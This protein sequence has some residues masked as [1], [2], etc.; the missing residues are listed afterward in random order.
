TPTNGGPGTPVTLTGTF[1][2]SGYYGLKFDGLTAYG[3]GTAT[4][5]TAGIPAEA[6]AS[7]PV[8]ALAD[9]VPSSAGQTF[10]LLASLSVTPP[11][12]ALSVGSTASLTP[13][14]TDSAGTAVNNPTITTWQVIDPGQINQPF[15]A[16]SSIGT[17]DSTGVFTAKAAGTTWVRAWSGNLSATAAVQVN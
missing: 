12:G 17:I 4:A 7:G 3:S 8:V 14:A 5:I 13:A 6:T 11:S 2:S 15:P 9:G 10:A 1:G 16:A